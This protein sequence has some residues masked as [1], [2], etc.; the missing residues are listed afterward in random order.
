MN[1]TDLSTLHIFCFQKLAPGVSQFAYTCVQDHPIWTNQQFWETTFYSNV[2]NQVRSLYLTAKD[3][4]HA[5]QLKRKVG[6]Y[7]KILK[8]Y[9]YSH[10]I[11]LLG[12]RE[13]S[14]G[15]PNFMCFSFIFSC[16]RHCTITWEIIEIYIYLQSI[17]IWC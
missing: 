4:N 3:D 11:F 15:F 1:R 16:I 8:L 13:L 12:Y 9:F 2:Q 7:I 5:V 10:I 17:I 14:Y 6:K